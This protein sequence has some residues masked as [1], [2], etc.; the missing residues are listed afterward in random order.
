MLLYVWNKSVYPF[1]SLWDPILL[2]F[3]ILFIYAITSHI[4]NKNKHNPLYR[5][6]SKGVFVKMIGAI[7]VCMVY[8]QVYVDGDTTWYYHSALCMLKLFPKDPSH[9]F[10]VWLSGPSVE[11]YFYFDES[12]GYPLY[13]FDPSAN[14]LC[15]IAVPFVFLGGLAFVPSAMLMAFASFFG[16]WKFYQVFCERFP[17]ITDKLAIAILFMP[18]VFFWG[19]GLSKDTITFTTLCWYTYSFYQFFIKRK[20]K[21]IYILTVFLASFFIVKIKPYVLFALLPGSIIWLSRERVKK[22]ENKFYRTIL[23][24]F[25][26]VLGI[27]IAYYALLQ[28]GNILGDYSLEKVLFKAKDSQFDLKQTYY[29]GN[30]FDIGDFEPNMAGALKVAH[31]AVFAGLF[32]PTML[33]VKNIV[34]F[35]AALENTFI[36]GFTVFL[37]VR[38]KIFS[39]FKYIFTDPLLLF[40][41]LFSV[42]FAFSVGISV[43]NFGTLVRLRIPL[44]PFY[45]AIL[46]IVN[47]LHVENSKKN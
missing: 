31:F 7:S 12:T 10:E 41:F 33:Q 2:P 30:S 22:I 29:Q 35:L 15:R 40:S 5:Y 32:Y 19:S 9:F 24:P 47:Y 13:W 11:N 37:L 27:F 38:L 23:A 28:S 20:R 39:F 42:F 45:I 43:S 6:F 1:L 18:S 3:Y 36:L 46:F 21:F 44:I 26:L 34:M 14:F 8:T 4:Q 25:G 16:I 17:T